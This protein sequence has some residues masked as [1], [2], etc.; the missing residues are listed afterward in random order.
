MSPLDGAAQQPDQESTG[1]GDRLPQTC[2]L[3]RPLREELA[4]DHIHLGQRDSQC[5]RRPTRCAELVQLGAIA[6][7]YRKCRRR[8]G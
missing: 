4:L 3:P 1:I 6:K 7:P 5:L 8:L 2:N